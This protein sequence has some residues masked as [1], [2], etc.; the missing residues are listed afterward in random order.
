MEPQRYFDPSYK[1]PTLIRGYLKKL[2]SDSAFGKILGKFN[3]RYFILDMN[4]YQFG[5]QDK[6]NSSK[7]HMFPLSDLIDIDPNPRIT[8]VCD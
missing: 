6:E 1:G 7:S 2:K 4:N 8:E 5:Y 3:K